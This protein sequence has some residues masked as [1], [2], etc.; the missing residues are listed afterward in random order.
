[1]ARVAT[2]RAGQAALLPGTHGRI[3]AIV[4]RAEEALGQGGE[5][6]N[7]ST[8]FTTVVSPGLTDIHHRQPAIINLNRFDD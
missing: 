4:R 8:I 2:D 1:M 5:S 7:S 6:L 3:V